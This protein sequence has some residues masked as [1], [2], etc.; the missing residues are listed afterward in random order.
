[1]GWRELTFTVGGLR[2]R[3][4]IRGKGLRWLTETTEEIFLVL[5]QVQRFRRASARLLL[6]ELADRVRQQWGW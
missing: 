2:G 4:Q 1:M 3:G 5:L 6:E